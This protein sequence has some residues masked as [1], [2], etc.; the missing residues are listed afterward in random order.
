METAAL[1][2]LWQLWGMGN[3]EPW[4][5]YQ[6]PPI[7]AAEGGRIKKKKE[8]EEKDDDFDVI[9]LE[10][11]QFYIP[12]DPRGTK[13][14]PKA[15]TPD[16]PGR[17]A[18]VGRE[19]MRQTRKAEEAAMADAVPKEL[20]GMGMRVNPQN[21]DNFIANTPRSTHIEDRRFYDPTK[22]ETTGTTGFEEGGDVMKPVNFYGMPWGRPQRY[23]VGGP[24]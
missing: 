14:W 22:D 15:P 7:F 5:R 10:E 1:L 9:P 8:K 12:Y 16:F 18:G 19:L 6:P 17:Y 3:D 20:F 24:A 23:A 13:T 11:A 4:K 21:W 2:L